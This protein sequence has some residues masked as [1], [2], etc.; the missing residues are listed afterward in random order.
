MK[1]LRTLLLL[2]S[3]LLLSQ[4]CFALGIDWNSNVIT[5]T[6][7][8]S[9]PESV[10]Q[11]G[12]ASALA[13]RAAVVDA[14]RNLA[15]IVY[16][17]ELE[18]QTTIAQLAV[19][20]DTIKTAVSGAIKNA[21]II[22]ENDLSNGNYQVTVSMPLFGPN[23]LSSAIGRT[24]GIVE[25]DASA[26]AVDN[27]AI[28]PVE[29][30]STTPAPIPAALP[31]PATTTTTAPVVSPPA[32]A[33]AGAFTGLVIDCRGLGI[34]RA[35]APNIVDV[36]GRVIY[37]S[38][39]IT[40]SN[41]IRHGIVTYATDD[42]PKSLAGAGT[43]PLIIKATALSDFHQNPMISKADA[44]KVLQAVQQYDFLKTCSVMFIQ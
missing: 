16:G 37:G 3:M 6:G 18:N 29:Q 34:E 20:S 11:T 39:N 15:S 9:A 12:Q 1:T 26:E 25:Q 40:D 35:M 44:D 7:I 22:D 36:D 32:I 42:N 4:T 5:A 8:G 23:S 33:P 38:K 27:F 17:V 10:T 28:P 2:I 43:M 21:R 41:V 30:Q 14:Y 13:R 19:K 31:V 24:K